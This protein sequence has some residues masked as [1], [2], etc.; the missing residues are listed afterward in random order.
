MGIAVAH[1]QERNM[2]TWTACVAHVAVDAETGELHERLSPGQRQH[3]LMIAS[4]NLAGE[5]MDLDEA[6]TLEELLGDPGGPVVAIVVDDWGNYDNDN[7]RGLLH[8]DV[9]L[10]MS[11]LPGLPVP[12]QQPATAS[13]SAS[14][15]N[16]TSMSAGRTP[17][18]SWWRRLTATRC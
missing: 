1:G 5:L 9:P 17:P 15:K 12:L 10:T 8:L 6:P 16:W 14:M 7:T 18:M 4:E 2:P 11:V 13:A 3:E